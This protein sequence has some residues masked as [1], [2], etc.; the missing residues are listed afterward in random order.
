MK[1]LKVNE[2]WFTNSWEVNSSSDMLEMTN[3]AS[4]KVRK[5]EREVTI[6]NE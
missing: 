5:K 6:S 1:G 3:W 2:K 4:E